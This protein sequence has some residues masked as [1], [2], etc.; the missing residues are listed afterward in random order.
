MASSNQRTFTILEETIY[1]FSLFVLNHKNANN[2]LVI[3]FS[4][5]E[6]LIL[7]CSLSNLSLIK[8][9]ELKTA[10]PDIHRCVN[11]IGHNSL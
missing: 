7:Y 3:S 11:R 6:N 9:D 2:L 5:T 1:S 4:E 8:S 10:G